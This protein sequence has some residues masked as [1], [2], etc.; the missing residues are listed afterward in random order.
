MVL[1]EAKVM[2]STHLELARPIMVDRGRRVVV[3]LA[4]STEQDAERWEWVQGG[5]AG[6]QAAYGDG[7]PEYTPAMVRERNPAYGT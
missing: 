7:E 5:T 4:E 1:V 2:D 3:V 6:L